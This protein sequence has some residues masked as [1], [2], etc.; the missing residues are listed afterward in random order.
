MPINPVKPDDLCGRCVYYP[1]NLPSDK[2][3]DED[4][5]VL[6]QKTCSYDFQVGDENCKLTRKTSCSIVNLERP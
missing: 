1:P 6:Q 4:W 5:A 2:Y 3:P